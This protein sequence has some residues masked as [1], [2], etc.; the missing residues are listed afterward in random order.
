MGSIIKGHHYWFYER[1]SQARD[2]TR[3]FLE[4]ILKKAPITTPHNPTP[5]A[6]TIDPLSE[7]P[8]TPYELYIKLLQ[9]KFGDLIDQKVDKQ[10]S[11]AIYLSISPC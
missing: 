11:K 6:P 1:W 3:E 10:I 5:I 8:L 7:M 4:Q 9:I 2:W